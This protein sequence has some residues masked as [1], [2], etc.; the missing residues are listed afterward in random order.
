MDQG[1]IV[2]ERLTPNEL[3]QYAPG[4][5]HNSGLEFNSLVNSL[6]VLLNWSGY[7]QHFSWAGLVLLI[8]LA[9]NQDL[10]TF[11]RQKLKTALVESAEGREWP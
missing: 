2:K 8:Q 4:K 3:Q 11:F 5:T 9:V 10:Y 6:K 1:F 7:L